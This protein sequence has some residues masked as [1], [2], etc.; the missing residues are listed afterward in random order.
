MKHFACAVLVS[1]LFA[2]PASAQIWGNW[3]VGVG[4]GKVKTTA[5]EL[6]S[7]VTVQPIISRRPSKGFGFAFAFNWFSADVNGSVVGESEKLGRLATR[8]IL[9]GVAY[10]FMNGKFAWAPTVVAGPSY[11]TLKVDDRWDGTYDVDGSSFSFAVRPGVSATYSLASHWA[12]G[13]FGGYIVNRPEFE[14]RTPTGVIETK[15]K[16][17]GFVLNTGVVFV[18]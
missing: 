14:I 11:N 2:S 8:P 4:V 16:G 13:A 17:D 9:A 10:T 3:G 7:K 5:D 6:E 1:L 15:W 12:I 18:F